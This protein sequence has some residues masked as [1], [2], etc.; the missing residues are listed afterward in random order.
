M[1]P[2]SLTLIVV[3]VVLILIIIYIATKGDFICIYSE[4]VVVKSN[5]NKTQSIHLKDIACSIDSIWM[6]EADTLSAT[7]DFSRM[8]AM[9]TDDSELF[10]TY[11]NHVQAQRQENLIAADT[12]E[13][14]VEHFHS[15]LDSILEHSNW[16]FQILTY[17]L[18]SEFHGYMQY[19]LSQAAATAI[20]VPEPVDFQTLQT[21]YTEKNQPLLNLHVEKY[22]FYEKHALQE[23]DE[24]IV[25]QAA[26]GRPTDP[27]RPWSGQPYGCRTQSQASFARQ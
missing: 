23:A 8:R 25:K 24:E 5:E 4:H 7:E 13:K 27:T 20:P 2:F 14:V 16:N 10:I 17:Q 9:Q 1:D 6:T 26:G 11:Y 21:T 18:R 3:V 15:S 12:I 19:T 22:L